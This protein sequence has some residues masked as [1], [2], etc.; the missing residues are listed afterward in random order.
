LPVAAAFAWVALR[1]L[2]GRDIY[3]INVV[4]F[5]HLWLDD[6]VAMLGHAAGNLAGGWIALFA[7]ATDGPPWVSAAIVVFGFVCLAGTW[8][9]L[10][11]NHVDGWYVGLSIALLAPVFFGEQTARRYLY[12]LLPVLLVHAVGALRRLTAGLTPMERKAAIAVAVLVP[13]AISAGSL[14]LVAG[15]ALD[16]APVL[17]GF[18]IR[19]SDMFDYYTARDDADARHGAAANAGVLAGFDAIG[20]ATPQDA[21]VMW[22]RPEYISVLAH[23]RA[24]PWF[25][26]DDELRLARSI[27]N[28]GVDYVALSGITKSDLDA[29][30]GDQAAIQQALTRFAIPVIVIPN[31]VTGRDEFILLKVDHA[32]VRAYLASR[33]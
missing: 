17:E 25:Y 20:R 29:R 5:A 10:R 19:W 26:A 28:R 8:L 3:A 2:E 23:R 16:H 1:P 21:R 30:Q 31:A 18:P 27:E 6:P 24:E 4:G 12:P 15:R 33:A 9:R 32:A 7:L 14:A 11:D 13:A 22:M